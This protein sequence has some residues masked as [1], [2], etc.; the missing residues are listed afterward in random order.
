M[1]CL[2]L[3]VLAFTGLPHLKRLCQMAVY[4][5]ENKIFTFPAPDWFQLNL[6]VEQ[7]KEKGL[8]IYK[9]TN[10]LIYT[11]CTDS[12]TKQDEYAKEVAGK[13]KLKTKWKVLP[14]PTD[15]E[16]EARATCLDLT[17]NLRS[18]DKLVSEIIRMKLC[19]E[20][21]L[22]SLV[23]DRQIML[24][25]KYRCLSRL[26]V[27]DA[28][29]VQANIAFK[30]KNVLDSLQAIE[31][32][33]V[34]GRISFLVFSKNYPR[35]IIQLKSGPVKYHMLSV[36]NSVRTT[37]IKEHDNLL[38]EAVINEIA[39]VTTLNGDDQIGYDPSDEV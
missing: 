3:L 2:N 13:L 5:K 34:D 28:V 4:G 35:Y 38:S 37:I 27:H 19:S 10:G 12:P 16:I 9:G 32:G 26:K 36:F 31:L 30:L 21:D 14:K 25:G 23:N 22:V 33:E 11:I 1:V 18:E 24:E 8:K 7:L 17:R 20:R 39:R 29:S 15:S 6:R